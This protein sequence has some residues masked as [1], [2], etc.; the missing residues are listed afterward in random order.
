VELWWSQIEDYLVDCGIDSDRKKLGITKWVLK[1]KAQEYLGTLNPAP[2]SMRDLK[3]ALL[4]RY[5]VDYETK[6]Q[7]YE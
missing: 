6:V 7:R 5:G 1:G 3:N 4:S 2:V